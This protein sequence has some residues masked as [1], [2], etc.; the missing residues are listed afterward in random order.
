MESWSLQHP[1]RGRL[2]VQVG[3]DR[4]FAAVEPDWKGDVEDKEI[5]EVAGD[6]TLAERVHA[7]RRNPPRRLQVRLE[8]ADGEEVVARY[9]AVREGRIP[10]TESSRSR[11]MRDSY[12]V[13][14]RRKPHLVLHTGLLGELINI[15]YRDADTVVEFDP[16]VGSRGAKR[17]QEMD[18]SPAKRV[19]YP[20]AAGVGKS[21]WALG[22]LLLG[23]LIGRIIGRIVEWLLALLPDWDLP[24]FTVPTIHLPVPR[25]P[26]LPWIHLPAPDIPLPQFDLPELPAWVRLAIEYQKL[27]VPLL[28]AVVVGTMAV[29]NHGK[30]ERRKMQ[31]EAEQGEKP[32]PR[33][34]R[35]AER[36]ALSG[37]GLG[38]RDQAG[39]QAAE[40]VGDVDVGRTEV[41]GGGAQITGGGTE[42][43]VA[44]GGAE[45]GVA[46]GGT[47]VG[48]THGGA[49]VALGGGEVT[50]GGTEFGGNDAAGEGDVDVT[51]VG[52]R[53][54]SR[55]GEAEAADLEGVLDGDVRVLEEVEKEVEVHG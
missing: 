39:E 28:I 33:R 37:G 55:S 44:S 12:T 49:E 7:L 54:R 24:E 27:W 43:G 29:R 23:P 2:I 34:G 26:E 21:G 11:K 31:W 1:E 41:T 14:D 10:L 50:G 42:V 52:G 35:R 30:S 9:S 8:D 51:D 6:A 40:E 45:G 3:Y 4:E 47:E 20:L 38:A 46:C 32:A 36:G 16:P 22:V 53:S 13:V 18:E 17:R 25:V 15:E 5:V 48:V 19:L